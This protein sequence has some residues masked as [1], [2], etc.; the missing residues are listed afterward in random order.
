MGWDG[1]GWDG[2]GWDGMGWDGMGW[3]GM[4]EAEMIECIP[5]NLIYKQPFVHV[6]VLCQLYEPP[7]E[8]P[9]YSLTIL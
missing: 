4:G 2:M 6:S 1:M 8:D 7:Q 3:D 5:N 9:N